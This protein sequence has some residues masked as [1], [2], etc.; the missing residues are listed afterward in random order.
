MSNKDKEIHKLNTLHARSASK[1][2]RN[3]I[4]LD[5]LEATS[6]TDFLQQLELDDKSRAQASA[7]ALHKRN[8]DALNTISQAISA[9]KARAE[10]ARRKVEEEKRRVEEEKRRV[11]EE[12]RRVEEKKRRAEEAERQ[13]RE[14]EQL[15]RRRK[16]EERLRQA[17]Q[18]KKA[19][20]GKKSAIRKEAEERARQAEER[21]RFA[22]EEKARQAEEARKAAEAPPGSET[23]SEFESHLNLIE[24]IPTFLVHVHSNVFSPSKQTS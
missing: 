8:A 12:K 13:K 9:T 7:Q 14:N 24:V 19:E 23:Q 15:E 3:S 4:I 1:T 2:Y 21:A 20:E 18:A 5:D 22:K 6:I 17:A 10:E 16:E 11:E